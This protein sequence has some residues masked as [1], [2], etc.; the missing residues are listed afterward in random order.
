MTSFFPRWGEAFKVIG[1]AYNNGERQMDPIVIGQAIDKY[2]DGAGMM[3]LM[4]AMTASSALNTKQYVEIVKDT[5]QR[6]I[7]LKM[8]EEVAQ[9]AFDHEKPIEDTLILAKRLSDTVLQREESKMIDARELMGNILSEAMDAGEQEGMVNFSTGFAALDREFTELQLREMVV[10]GARPGHGKTALMVSMMD[11]MLEAGTRIMF[12]SGEMR[13][14][15][16]GGRLAAYRYDRRVGQQIS[17]RNLLNGRMTKEEWSN[18]SKVMGEIGLYADRL[19]INRFVGSIT[20]GQIRNRINAYEL[21][22][23]RRP[24]VVMVDYLGLMESDEPSRSILERITQIT[25][26]LKLLVMEYN[27]ILIVASQLNRG[28]ENRA[29]KK[30]NLADLRDSG[31]TEQDADRV[32]F[33]YRSEMS[34]GADDY[35]PHIGEV[36]QAKMREGPT[37]QVDLYFSGT[38]GFK[39]LR[40]EELD[41]NSDKAWSKEL[42]KWQ[43]ADAA[44]TAEEYE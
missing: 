33:L 3:A 5:S 25:R 40:T 13:A 21:R 34:E 18:A 31:S 29:D 1:K 30:P 23:G 38:S 42:H 2:C 10:I 36:I 28:I 4:D 43:Q 44:Q 41:I 20:P 26:A 39:P 6:R 14:E 16:V 12:F 22:N 35:R 24:D 17:S 27:I 32:W 19:S 7:M 9:G 37:G 15:D 11:R 8:A